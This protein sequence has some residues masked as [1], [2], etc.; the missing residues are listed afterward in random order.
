M[1]DIIKL[2]KEYSESL[3]QKTNVVGTG[4]GEK[5]SGGKPTGMSLLRIW[6]VFYGSKKK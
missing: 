1:Q 6:S 5:F 4:V 3:S 2:Q